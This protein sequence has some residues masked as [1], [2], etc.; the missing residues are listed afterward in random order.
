MKEKEGREGKGE[1]GRE[2][3][4]SKEGRESTNRGREEREEGTGR[5][6]REGRVEKKEKRWKGRGRAEGK[7]KRGMDDWIE[8]RRGKG[9]WRRRG[10]E[11]RRKKGKV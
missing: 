1:R 7:G 8:G 10:R 3:G 4:V 2:N 11:G 9:D 5:R 6:C